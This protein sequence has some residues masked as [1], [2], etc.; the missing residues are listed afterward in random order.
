MLSVCQLDLR[1]QPVLDLRLFP[2]VSCIDTICYSESTGPCLV[3]GGEEA[4]SLPK[5]HWAR[6]VSPSDLSTTQMECI[7][8]ESRGAKK[9]TCRRA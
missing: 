3:G 6:Q 8:R 2:K 1:A 4:L 7:P 9:S 5:Q